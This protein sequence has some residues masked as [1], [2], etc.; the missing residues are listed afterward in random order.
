MR[1]VSCHVDGKL[2]AVTTLTAIVVDRV[3]RLA[4]IAIAEEPT[5]ER[6]RTTGIDSATS[7]L[8]S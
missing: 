8:G 4:G 7:S 1:L 2:I 3:G 6:E 5:G